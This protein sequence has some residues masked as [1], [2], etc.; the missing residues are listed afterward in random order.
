MEGFLL[1]CSM[2]LRGQES[3]GE[4]SIGRIVKGE[5]KILRRSREKGE[6]RKTQFTYDGR[7]GMR[8]MT[9][10]TLDAKSKKARRLR[11]YVA[12]QSPDKE[13]DG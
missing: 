12:G 8:M 2:Q 10:V 6:G 4:G 13:R 3:Q 11:I 7:Q 1:L 9:K 5:K